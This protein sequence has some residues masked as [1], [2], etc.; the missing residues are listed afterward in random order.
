[1]TMDQQ[2]A[3]VEP[4]NTSR[5]RHVPRSVSN[6]RIWVRTERSESHRECSVFRFR[7]RLTDEYAE[8]SSFTDYRLDFLVH[9][10]FESNSCRSF[11]SEDNGLNTSAVSDD[12]DRHEICSTEFE[13]TDSSRAIESAVFETNSEC[14]RRLPSSGT[15][16]E[17]V[18]ISLLLFLRWYGESYARR[19][20][21]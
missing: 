8:S 4:S 7:S 14:H 11:R 6:S 21:R 3:C 2:L 1:M 19:R 16:S 12:A 17:Q 20:S 5:G 13:I 18:D 9:L 10:G 15:C